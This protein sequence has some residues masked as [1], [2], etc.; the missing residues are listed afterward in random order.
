MISASFNEGCAEADAPTRLIRAEH[1]SEYRMQQFAIVSGLPT[2][3]STASHFSLLRLEQIAQRESQLR[4]EIIRDVRANLVS[5]YNLPVGQ[6][7]RKEYVA[8]LKD[9]ARYV[10]LDYQEGRVSLHLLSSMLDSGSL[11]TLIPS[12]SALG[13]TRPRLSRA[14]SAPPFLAV[15][16]RRA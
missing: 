1:Q 8:R 12:H 11:S 9:R 10:H 5:Y 13:N 14:R 15:V 6:G 2:F 7:A 4:G 16:T 3:P